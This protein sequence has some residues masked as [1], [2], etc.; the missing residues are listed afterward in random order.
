[1]NPDLLHLLDAPAQAGSP[2]AS[3]LM[4]I[5]MVAIV[6]YFFVYRPQQ[7]DEATRKELISSLQRGDK[8]ITNSGIHGK[9]H[10]AKGE[11]LVLEISPGAYL[12]VDRDAVKGKVG[13]PAPTDGKAAEG[14][15]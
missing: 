5:A 8:V 3:M 10:E 4:P 1:M 13:D 14:K 6:F 7:K 11:T 9:L 2:F 12:T 15:K